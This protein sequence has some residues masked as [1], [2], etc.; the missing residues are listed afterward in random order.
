MRS[1]NTQIPQ[2]MEFLRARDRVTWREIERVGRMRG[3]L[4]KDHTLKCDKWFIKFDDDDD[5]DDGIS[6]FRLKMINFTSY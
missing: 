1:H 2:Q 6:K 5:N 3:R 4:S